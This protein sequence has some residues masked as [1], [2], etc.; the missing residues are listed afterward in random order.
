[1]LQIFQLNAQENAG[2]EFIR[3]PR[4][5][6][7]AGANDEKNLWLNLEDPDPAELKYIAELFRLPEDFLSDPLDPA[8][9]PR[10]GHA[11]GATLIIARAS[12]HPENSAE[13]AARREE[14]SYPT[15]PVGIIITANSLVTVCRIP[16]LV[17]DLLGQKLGAANTRVHIGIALKLLEKISIRFMKHL[18]KLDDLSNQIEEAMQEATRNEDLRRI[19]Q[20]EKTLVYFLNALKANAL[21]LDKL[22]TGA[23]FVWHGD[24]K[25]H[26]ADA[27]IECRQAVEMGEIFTQ[28][29]ANM[30]DIYASMIS[31]NMNTVMKFLTAITLILMA[32]SI[33]VGL[34]GM[35]VPLPF[36][37]SPWALPLI[38]IGTVGVCWALWR[39][40]LKKHWM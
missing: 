39:Y 7:N 31:N 20:L 15:V 30:S 19:L 2:L 10:A 23:G 32:P 37:E 6:E 9:R 34:Y 5:P 21:V 24:E 36:Q 1:M 13:G 12:Y 14:Q 18:Q 38:S 3:L 26:L 28:I 27:L 17:A 40:L 33:I 4:L 29:T 11:E 16:G 35:N 25:E 22:M 8:E